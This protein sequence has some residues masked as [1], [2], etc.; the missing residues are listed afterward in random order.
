L[1]RGFGADQSDAVVLALLLLVSTLAVLVL[2]RSWRPPV[3]R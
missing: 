3:A 2:V 1:W